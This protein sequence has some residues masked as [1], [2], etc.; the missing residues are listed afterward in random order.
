MPIPEL[1][2]ARVERFCEEHVPPHVR[3]QVRL[4]VEVGPGTLTIV[5]RRPPW[6]ADFGPE[7]SRSPVVRFRHNSRTK[8]WTLYWRDRNERFHR[9]DL[10]PPSRSIDA[11]LEEV[12]RDPTSLF[13]G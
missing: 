11:L 4:E 8:L 5:E 6:N 10:H 9:Y 1:A 13:W 3:D 2:L 7:W 12:K